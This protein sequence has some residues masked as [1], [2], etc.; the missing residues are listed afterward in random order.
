MIQK[1]NNTSEKLLSYL[2]NE[3]EKNDSYFKLKN[4]K[5]FMPLVVE[6]IGFNQISLVHYGEQ[7]G[8]LM[9]DPEIVFYKNGN[10]F[11]PVFLQNDYIGQYIEVMDYSENSNSFVVSNTRGY[12][13]IID[14]FNSLWSKNIISQQELQIK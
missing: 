10:S 13:S 3:A 5:I 2:W 12:N 9:R 6:L 14:F 1:L 11:L 8:D 4:N 7:N